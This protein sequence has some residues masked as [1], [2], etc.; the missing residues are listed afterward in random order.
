MPRCLKTVLFF[1]FFWLHRAACRI[2]VP[3]PGSNPCP[4]QWKR[5]VLTT[6]P[7]GNYHKD[8]TLEQVGREIPWRGDSKSVPEMNLPDFLCF[9]ASLMKIFTFS[10]CH[11]ISLP[12]RD[13]PDHL[14]KRALS[15][16]PYPLSRFTFFTALS[17]PG[18][19]FLLFR[20][21][22]TEVKL[23]EARDLSVMFTSRSSESAQGLTQSAQEIPQE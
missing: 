16:T 20:C 22:P 23:P 5:G 18:I 8:S 12:Q 2:L 17:L 4:L 21:F 13:F 3:R 7:P 14:C 15:I 1:F 11:R 10:S 9:V 6:G 19:T